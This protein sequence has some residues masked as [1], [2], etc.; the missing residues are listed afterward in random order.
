MKRIYFVGAGGIG[1]ANL[2]RYYLSK[3]LDVAGYDRTP[4][5]L[6]DALSE[7]GAHLVFEDNADLI[8]EAFRSPEDTLVVYTPA[9]PESNAILSFFR[10][11]GFEVIK[12]AALLGKITRNSDGICVAGSH[13]KTTTSS[14]IAHILDTSDVGCNAFLGG[15]LR[16]VGSNLILSPTSHWSVIEADEYDRSFHHLSP[17]VAI[18]TSTDPDHLD[19]YGDEEHYLEAFSIFTSLIRPGGLLLLHTGL[20]MKPDVA[21]GVTILTYSASE[22]GD[23]HAENITFA[24]GRLTF[25]FVG[26]DTR[27]DGIELG[28]PIEINV[29]NAVAATAAAL[30]A[31]ASADDIRKGLATF[32]GAKRRFEFHLKD[33]VHPVLIDDY[34]HSPNEVSASIRSVRRLY[35]GHRI[36]VIFQP[37]LYTRTRDFAPEFADALSEADELILTEIYPARELPIEGV[38]SDII[39]DRVKSKKKTFCPRKDLL[40][41]IK[42]RNFDVIMTLG[43]AD[44]DRLLPEIKELLLEKSR[45]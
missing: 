35:P 38:T 26:P 31:G 39:F 19:I 3:G 14:M 6:T 11:N 9:V 34:A 7:E 2:V 12:R 1:M 37:H 22:G 24:E 44:I 32:L 36:S 15:I 17:L 30:F 10:R 40:T 4:S 45:D 18:I 21:E 28:V 13:G 29:D 33:D 27:I 43:A 16:N 23:C 20:K 8:P 25:D 5:Q 42:K 41:L